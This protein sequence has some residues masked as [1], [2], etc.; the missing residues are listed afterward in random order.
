MD[1]RDEGRSI[2]IQV[3]EGRVYVARYSSILWTQTAQFAGN[4]GFRSRERDDALGHQ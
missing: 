1:Q 2:G 3:R 4:L